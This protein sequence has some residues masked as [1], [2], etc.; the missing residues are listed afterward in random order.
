MLTFRA[1]AIL[2]SI[3]EVVRVIAWHRSLPDALERAQRER[4]PVLV[5]V[6]KDG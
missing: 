3:P 6:W 2:A 5:Y 4:R 1:L